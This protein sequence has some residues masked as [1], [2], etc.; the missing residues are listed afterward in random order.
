ML[1]FIFAAL[2]IYSGV[3]AVFYHRFRI[4]LPQNGWI[5]FVF[6]M[7]LAVMVLSPLISRILEIQGHDP[8]ARLTAYA[9]YFWMGFL[10]LSFSGSLVL[11][12]LDLVSWAAGMLTPFPFPAGRL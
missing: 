5:S 1:K 4:L 6:V 12:L 10:F 9:A 8:I 7:F 11:Y 3:H 2:L